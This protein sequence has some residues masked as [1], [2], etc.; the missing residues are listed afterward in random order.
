MT[1]PV[2]SLA[3]VPVAVAPNGGRRTRMDHP[4][5][6]IEPAE[7]A[8]TAA[9]SL[10][11]GAAMIHVHVRD[12]EG[13]HLL[14][15]EAYRR[16]MAAI[17]A[18][19]G[20]RMVI[21]ITSEALG[22]YGPEAQ[23]AIVREVRPQAV[24]LAL[25]EVLPEGADEAAFGAFLAWMK[26]ER[27]AP[28]F[29][30]YDPAEVDRLD[31][32]RR[33]GVVPFEEPPVLY[34]LGRYTPGQTSH[35]ADLLPF[36]APERPRFTRFMTCAFGRHEAACTVMSGML[37]GGLRVGF[38]NNLFLPSG[39]IAPSNASLVA[40]A[41]KGLAAVGIAPLDGTALKADWAQL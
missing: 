35:P 26:R 23:M 27:I 25:R 7:L 10:E 19:I 31:A 1:A 24:S 36:L 8:R 18:E 9:E 4:A 21:Q 12:R 41:C 32:L 11:A 13:R 3:S 15:A 17:R 20:E 38:E 5:L 2:A 6:P 39:E 34:V 14:D 40:A 37:G 33:R 30:L 16:A 28:Q 22:I 29:I